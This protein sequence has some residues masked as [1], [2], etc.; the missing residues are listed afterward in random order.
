MSWPSIVIAPPV[1]VEIVKAEHQAASVDLPEPLWPT[2]AVVVPAGIV[3][4]T[5]CR[6]CRAGS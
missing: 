3:K 4:L 6:I 1:T 5:S 2:T